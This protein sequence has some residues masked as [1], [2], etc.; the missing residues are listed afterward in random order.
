LENSNL[1]K[2]INSKI[3]PLS[4]K[5]ENQK[6][7]VRSIIEND[8]TFCTGI[9]GTGKTFVAAG[10]ASEKLFNGEIAKIVVTRPLVCTGKDI[11][12]LPGEIDEKV[13][14]YLAPLEENFKF[15]LNDMYRECFRE[16]QIVY[17]PLELMRGATFNSSI[18]ILDEAQNC[19]I[20]QI[21]MFIT[22]IGQGSKVI[23]NGDLN[24]TDLRR[25]GASALTYCINKLKDVKGVGVV[26]F[27]AADIQ[28]NGIIG[29]VLNALEQ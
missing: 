2:A 15:F 5:T 22:R 1:K 25:D 20:E 14:P 23:V 6:K 4:C 7:Y 16:G 21:K 9:S 10:L 27:T 29:R 12:A 26:N 18:M 3:V 28:R 11:G 17:K 13:M 8:I 24:Q 19:S